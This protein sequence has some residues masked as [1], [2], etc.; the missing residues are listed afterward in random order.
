SG[1]VDDT[2]SGSGVQEVDIALVDSINRYWAGPVTGWTG[3][4]GV[5]CLPWQAGTFV[6]ITS[7]TWSY[8]NF[9]GTTFSAGAS[10]SLY[11]R[12]IDKAGN[13]AADPPSFTSGGLTFTVDN[14]PPTWQA[15]VPTPG[16]TRPIAPTVVHGP[17]SLV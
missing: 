14:S 8:N 10:Y 12:A 3:N 1:T 4:C 16:R 15:L 7:G 9:N 5:S 11:V 13:I 2:A 17:A 6:G